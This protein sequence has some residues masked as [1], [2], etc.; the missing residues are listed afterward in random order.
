[1]DNRHVVMDSRAKELGPVDM[2]MIRGNGK[3]IL[4]PLSHMGGIK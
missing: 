4:W 2:D 3:W 1:M